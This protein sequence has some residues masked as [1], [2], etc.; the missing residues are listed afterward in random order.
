MRNEIPFEAL[1]EPAEAVL[2][3]TEA[4]LATFLQAPEEGLSDLRKDPTFMTAEQVER[5]RC[6]NEMAQVMLH[7]FHKDSIQP[8]IRDRSIPRL[9][10]HTYIETIINPEVEPTLAL[11]IV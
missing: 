3:L 6:L 1:T 11:D 7:T 4:E 9:E 5:A 8:L 10:G 2:G